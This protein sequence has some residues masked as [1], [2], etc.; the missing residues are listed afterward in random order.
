MKN[1]DSKILEISILTL[2]FDEDINFDEKK[3][4][5]KLWL[6]KRKMQFWL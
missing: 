2:K 1:F 4:M 5:F 6:L 3:I